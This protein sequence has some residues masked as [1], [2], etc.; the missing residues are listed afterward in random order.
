[1]L[2][3][4]FSGYTNN[5]S[6]EYGD[7]IMGVDQYGPFAFLYNLLWKLRS[8][9]IMLYAVPKDAFAIK[10]IFN[11]FWHFLIGYG[12]SM[13]DLY[14]PEFWLK[15]DTPFGE[16]N[17]YNSPTALQ[18]SLVPTSGILQIILSGGLVGAGLLLYL[19]FKTCISLDKSIL[20]L[21][22][23]ILSMVT[24]SS[25]PYVYIGTSFYLSFNLPW[26]KSKIFNYQVL[27]QDL[28]LNFEKCINYL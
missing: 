16:V 27:R 7:T 15:Y 22:V 14:V 1:M 5:V 17:D 24:V 20:V 6:Y 26:K 10:A 4:N 2:L 12:V 3:F 23:T 8:I 25:I 9:D 11:D 19:L 28:L 18:Q 21:I 13:A